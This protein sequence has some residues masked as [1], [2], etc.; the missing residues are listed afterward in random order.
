MNLRGSLSVV[1]RMDLRAMRIGGDWSSRERVSYQSDARRKTPRTLKPTCFTTPR[2][3]GENRDGR[4]IAYAVGK[5]DVIRRSP[6]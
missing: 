3:I 4:Q 1:G 6:T 2:R 5:T